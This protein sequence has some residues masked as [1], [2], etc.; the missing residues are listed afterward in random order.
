MNSL[1][2]NINNRRSGGNNFYFARF[3]SWQ[4][5]MSKGNEWN[6]ELRANPNFKKFYDDRNFTSMQSEWITEETPTLEEL[7]K[8]F[9]TR[10]IEQDLLENVTLAFDEILA[11]IDMGGS[12]KKSKLIIT[13]RPQGI[14]DF[15]L[16]SLGLFTEQEFY[17][18]KLAEESP[19]EFP[20]EPK[21]I[22]PNISVNRNQLGD[23]WYVSNY[24]GNKY[25]MTQQDKGTQKAMLEGYS[26]NEIPN[27]F[28]SFKTNQKKSY[29]L[30]K[31]EGGSAKRVDLYVPVGGLGF[32]SSSGML[33]RALPLFM[34]A[35]FFESVGIQT[36]LNATRLY[37]SG[38]N[39]LTN[40]K[41]EEG[42]TCITSTIK[43]FGEELDFTKLAVA[44]ADVRTFRYNLWKLS[45]AI[46]GK[47]T[48]AAQYGYG[49]TLYE[50][51]NF[52][53][54]ARRY[55]N[56][57][58]DE[59]KNNNKEWVEIPKPLMLFG[60]VPN[61][62]DTWEYNGNK[63]ESGYKKIV[64]EFYRILD[65]VDF[66]YNDGKKASERI[67][68]RYVETGENDVTEYK[69]YVQ[70]ILENAYSVAKGEPYADAKEDKDKLMEEFEEKVEKVSTFLSE[71]KR[72][73]K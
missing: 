26:K 33:Q 29:L 68:E 8:G 55:K 22:V 57:Y 40:A 24:S 39:N 54:T 72:I 6:E 49:S 43:D 9:Y 4:E 10:F 60:G 52:N 1:N 30:F 3:D 71:I 70:S 37:K 62:D 34:A 28:K 64:K 7:D 19:L 2:W 36:R 32:M 11:D 61:P 56:W 17:S 65:T 18:E 38:G 12:F 51:N 20:K 5:L 15:G 63:D 48:G 58:Y 46:T 44:V 21:G 42:L 13:D 67:Y 53:N 66:Y 45:P 27:S 23:F 69:D 41:Y 14:F 50:G 47:L 25:K 16:A 59:I 31:K 35:K 73:A